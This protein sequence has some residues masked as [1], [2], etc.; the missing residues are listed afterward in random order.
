M[1]RF[2]AAREVRLDGV[3]SPQPSGRFAEALLARPLFMA[4]GLLET[5]DGL[6]PQQA[7]RPTFAVRAHRQREVTEEALGSRTNQ[8]AKASPL[9]LTGELKLRRVV[10]DDDPRQLGGP[11]G[12][13]AEMRRQDRFRRDLLV[14]EESVGRFELGIIQRFRKALCGPFGE[15]IHQKTQSPIQALVAQI[16]INEFRG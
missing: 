5:E 1:D 12:G 4:D 6:K 16:G 3:N 2:N 7:Q 9:L 11:P 14:A 13:L 10:R 15:A 8:V